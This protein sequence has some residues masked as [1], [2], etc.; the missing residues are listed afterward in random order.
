M[1]G[2]LEMDV[3]QCIAAYTDL[4]ESVFRKRISLLPFNFR[5]KVKSRFD[6]A[7]LGAAVLKI[8]KQSRASNTSERDLFNDGVKRGCRT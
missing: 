6:S 5:G 3:D 4:A 1:L 2:R 7:K 8:V